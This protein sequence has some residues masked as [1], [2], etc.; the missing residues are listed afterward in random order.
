MAR[1][2]AAQAKVRMHVVLDQVLWAKCYL[3]IHDRNY[4]RGFPPGAFSD[5]VEKSLRQY[6][7][8]MEAR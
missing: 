1:P 3:L 8:G 4:E 2:K 5:L 6:L 7:D